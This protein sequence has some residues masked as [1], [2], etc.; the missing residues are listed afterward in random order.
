LPLPPGTFDRTETPV[1]VEAVPSGSSLLSVVPRRG[2]GRAYPPLVEQEIRFTSAA[3]PRVAWSAVGTGPN[4][5]VSGLW[6]SHLELDWQN[7]AIRWFV[8][9]LA[10]RFRVVRYDRPGT[11]L[12]DR[13]APSPGNLDA[14]VTV[15]D[16]VVQAAGGGEPF[17]LGTSSGGCVAIRYAVAQANRMRRL[18]LYGTYADGRGIAPEEARETLVSVVSTHW[19]LGSR[20]LADVFLPDASPAERDAFARFQRHSAS[21]ETAAASLRSVY[22]MDVT[23]DLPRVTVPTLVLHRRADHTIPAS[24]GREVAAGVPGAAFVLLEGADHFPWRGDAD[25]VVAQVARFLGGE[26][27]V[28]A[29]APARSST[30]PAGLDSLSDRELEVLRLVAAGL[31]DD[32]IAERLVLSPHT[33]HRHVANIRS[34]LQLTSRTA[35]AAAAA[36]A[37]LV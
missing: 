36:R 27:P 24:L 3:G 15:L 10:T 7:P 14:E 6:C 1:C 32:E 19:G 5:V 22:A 4:L 29:D 9:R 17:L 12:S 23:A 18:V 35:A 13:D 21:A 2:G 31:S 16:A 28:G 37:G 25:A 11:G 33:V 34:K 26:R 8:E 20:I 30:G